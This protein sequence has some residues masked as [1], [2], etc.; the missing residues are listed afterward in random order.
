MGKL[1]DKVSKS[2][3]KFPPDYWRWTSVMYEEDTFRW[4]LMNTRPIE[5][6]LE[7]GT[8]YGLSAALLAEFAKRV[9]TVDVVI[10][11]NEEGIREQVW[12]YLE[13]RDKINFHLTQSSRLKKELIQSLKFDFAFIDGQHLTENV[14][15]DFSLTRACGRVLFHDYRN[16]WPDVVEFVD[17]LSLS[18][19]N[20]ITK[21]NFALVE[22]RW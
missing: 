15:F 17:S 19:W 10:F 9:E 22:R 8:C 11:D 12:K 5:C 7:I 20:K 18:E 13:V 4:F 21:G 14:A 3:L 1:Y 16:D 2:G 6:V